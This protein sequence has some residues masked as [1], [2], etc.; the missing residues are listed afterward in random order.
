M[1]K[2]SNKFERFVGPWGRE[3]ASRPVLS[4]VS[5]ARSGGDAAYDR[6]IATIIR[7]PKNGP[8]VSRQV[9]SMYMVAMCSRLAREEWTFDDEVDHPKSRAMVLTSVWG[10]IDG[11]WLHTRASKSSLHGCF[12]KVQASIPQIPLAQP[13]QLQLSSLVMDLKGMCTSCTA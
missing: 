9:S 8:V 12:L 4:A 2:D 10:L 3:I 7:L 13:P 6:D 1:D 5:C 11:A